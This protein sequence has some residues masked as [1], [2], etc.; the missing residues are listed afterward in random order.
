MGRRKQKKVKLREEKVKGEGKKGKDG[1]TETGNK[2]M[3]MLFKI[4]PRPRRPAKV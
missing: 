2:K 3:V 1:G 4:P